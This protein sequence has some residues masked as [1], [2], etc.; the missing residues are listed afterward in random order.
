MIVTFPIIVGT[1]ETH[2]LCYPRPIDFI[3]LFHC[4]HEEMYWPSGDHK[5]VIDY[6][7]TC[8]L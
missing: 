4:L 3:I 8:K 6:K 2:K 1:I 5:F 7:Y